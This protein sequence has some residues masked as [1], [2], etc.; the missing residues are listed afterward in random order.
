MAEKGLKITELAKL[1]GVSKS[2]VHHYLNIGLLHPPKKYGLSLANYDWS[3]LSK[4]KRINELRTN[5]K[6]PLAAIREILSKEDILSSTS[7]QQTAQSLIS[8][9]EEEKKATRARKSEMKRVEIMDAAIALFSRNGYENTTLESIADSLNIAKSTVYLYFET[10]EHLFMECIERLTLVAVPEEAWDEIRREKNALNRLKKRGLAFHKAFPSYKGI[11]TMTKA[12]LGEENQQLAEKAK[13]TLS[14]MTRPIA[15][16]IRRGIADG[17]FRAVDEEVVAHLILAMG[18]G[19]GCRLMMDSSYSIEQG[20]EV[21]F[22]LVSHGLLKNGASGTKEL[23]SGLSSGEV[24]DLNG[25]ISKVE[26]IRFGNQNYLPAKMGEAEVRIDPGQVKEIRFFQRESSFVVELTSID[27][28]TQ[29]AEVDGNLSLSGEVAIGA[30]SIQLKNIASLVLKAKERQGSD[31]D[32][33]ERT[34]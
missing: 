22:D 25:L 30:F 20:L 15:K 24:T 18:E 28:E 12:V 8:A 14:H 10:K 7:S 27:G 11:L 13:N 16:D 3:H 31:V 2:T 19:L 29:M 9:L 4:L 21:M 1:S 34:D 6:L 23:E 32:A 5:R 33:G 26:K 17:I